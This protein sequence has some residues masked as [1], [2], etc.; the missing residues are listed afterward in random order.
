MTMHESSVAIGS[1]LGAG[2]GAGALLTWLCH[3]RR[4]YSFGF[5][6]YPVALLSPVE[7]LGQ[8]SL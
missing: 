6:G 8:P 5:C 7:S 1:T 3:N 2:A 4:S